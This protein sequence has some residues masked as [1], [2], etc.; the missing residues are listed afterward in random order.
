MC[1]DA[2]DTITVNKF[3]G[4]T[5]IH[6]I[7]ADCP[8]GISA[9]QSKRGFSKLRVDKEIIN[10]DITSEKEYAE[11]TKA[12]LMPLV[13]HLAKKNSVFI[14][15]SDKMLFALRDGMQQA[16]IRFSQLL[17][18]VKNQAVI[19]RMDFLPMY[20]IIAY[21]WK[22]THKFYR[23]KSKSVLY[24]PKP[25]RSQY[26]PTSKPVG[27][28]RHL[29]LTGTQIGDTVCDSFMGGGTTLLA[30]EQ[31]RRKCLGIELDKEYI[32]T[33]IQRWEQL[34]GKKAVKLEADKKREVSHG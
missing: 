27:L 18:W 7:N 20:E 16:G 4:N 29:I 3:I 13:P 1:A 22:G 26:H 21:G 2:T 10:D 34:T 32:L 6:Q 5:I 11:F 14:F 30:C 8:Y 15:N 31:T 23:S 25:V 33:T 9:V 19:G 12:W 28:I 17:I 24:Y